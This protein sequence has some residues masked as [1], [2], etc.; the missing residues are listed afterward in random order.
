MHFPLIPSIATLSTTSRKTTTLHFDSRSP[1]HVIHTPALHSPPRSTNPIPSNPHP[2]PNS[3]FQKDIME[4]HNQTLHKP[5]HPPR[6]HN[7]TTPSNPKHP[8]T[9]PPPKP[10]PSIPSTQNTFK[11]SSPIN[12]AI[13]SH[14]HPLQNP[15]RTKTP[16]NNS[17]SEPPQFRT[18]GPLTPYPISLDTGERLEPRHATILRIVDRRGAERNIVVAEVDDQSGNQTSIL[19]A[20]DLL[21]YIRDDGT[22][23]VGRRITAEEMYATLGREAQGGHF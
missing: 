19:L 9:P 14:P 18:H 5:R 11:T 8:T 15:S 1:R 4:W 12:P 21:D 6:Q 3:H 17:L 22:A 2:I 20:L 13:P 7:P 10:N 16:K 23:A